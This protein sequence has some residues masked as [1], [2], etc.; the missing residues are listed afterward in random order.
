MEANSQEAGG[1]HEARV[2]SAF[3]SNYR[4][5]EFYFSDRTNESYRVATVF[6][7]VSRLLITRGGLVG[8][9]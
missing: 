6:S 5:L 4:L 3:K 7:E 9:N 2:T 8:S 1:F